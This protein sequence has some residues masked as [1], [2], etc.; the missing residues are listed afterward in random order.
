MTCVRWRNGNRKLAAD[1]AQV[2]PQCMVSFGMRQSMLEHHLVQAE[3]RVAKGAQLIAKQHAIVADLQRRGEDS[4]TAQ[5]LLLT[6][7]QMQATHIINRDRLRLR[8]G[9]LHRHLLRVG[10][11]RDRAAS[12]HIGSPM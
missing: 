7:K 3:R 10:G 1:I 9:I 11:R 12:D 4:S 8:L 2:S 5:Q 6:F